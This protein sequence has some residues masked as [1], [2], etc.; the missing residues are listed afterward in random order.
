VFFKSYTGNLHSWIQHLGRFFGGSILVVDILLGIFFIHTLS[1]PTM[2]KASHGLAGRIYCL[3]A[4]EC[5]ATMIW[6]VSPSGCLVV[7]T[8]RMRDNATHEN[9]DRIQLVGR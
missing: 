8:I 9:M 5:Y 1:L 2:L 4:R 7:F 6:I 3:N